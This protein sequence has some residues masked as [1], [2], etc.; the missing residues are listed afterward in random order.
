MPK[1]V[2]STA[3]RYLRKLSH[4][5][6]AAAT[7]ALESAAAESIGADHAEEAHA[8]ALETIERESGR[9]LDTAS[10]EELDRVFLSDGKEALGRLKNEGPD[11]ELSERH[12]D[13]LEAIVEVDGSR[14]TL[15]F[16]E[17]DHVDLEDGTL[18][19]W[20]GVT[21]KFLEQISR[22][23]ASV[24]RVDLDGK[25]QGTGF[26]ITDGLIL[27]NR[28]VLQALATQKQSGEWQFLGEPSITFDANP[29]KSRKRRVKIRKKVIRTGTQPIDRHAIDYK[30][31]DFAILECEVSDED[32]LP[33][34]LLLESDA[35]KVAVGRPIFT[36][37]YP[38]NPGY[39]AYAS[40]VLQKLFQY[41]YGVKRFAPGEIDRG[42][43]TAADGT[44]ETVFTHDSTTLGGNSGSCVVDLGNDGRLVVGLHFAGAPKKAN[45]AHSNALLH[46]TFGDLGLSWK[47]WLPPV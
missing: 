25:H 26:V 31:L 21:A 43:G 28:H 19:Q 27:T 44:G 20:K 18:G 16:S 15:M 9:K 30:K 6:P 5:V 22:V 39:G 40:D 2:R 32:R 8:R 38:A 24:G 14:P 45:F 29:D 11:A 47:E 41:R 3:A 7:G 36:I 46:E 17:D 10:K 33:E 12:E 35:D 34:P 13:A 37:G 23:A 4:G 42:L 1:E